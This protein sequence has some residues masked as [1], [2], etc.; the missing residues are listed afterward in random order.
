MSGL[1]IPTPQNEVKLAAFVASLF[2]AKRPRIV[3]AFEFSAYPLS[4]S[5]YSGKRGNQT[6]L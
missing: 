4:P 1:H 2:S 5:T 6:L 3:A